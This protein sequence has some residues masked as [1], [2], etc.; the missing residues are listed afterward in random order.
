MTEFNQNDIIAAVIKGLV[1]ELPEGSVTIYETKTKELVDKLKADTSE[2]L[3]E[4]V[5]AVNVLA[6]VAF[7]MEAEGIV[8]ALR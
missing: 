4:N 7:V 1:E 6:Y 2:D 8:G 3:P 5:R